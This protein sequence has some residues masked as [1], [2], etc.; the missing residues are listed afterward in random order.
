MYL[1]FAG[2]AGPLNAFNAASKLMYFDQMCWFLDLYFLL[3]H[4]L[5]WSA[6]SESGSW[7]WPDVVTQKDHF[8]SVSYNA[9]LFQ[10]HHPYDLNSV[11][12]ALTA[13]RMMQERGHQTG[14]QEYSTKSNMLFWEWEHRQDVL[15]GYR[16]W[17]QSS[18]YLKEFY[19]HLVLCISRSTTLWKSTRKRKE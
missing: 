7:S 16:L 12:A 2:H 10:N 5:S 11:Y 9:S 17:W 18:R 1:S 6:G 14:S 8:R 19:C 4:T 13:I 15:N 3:S